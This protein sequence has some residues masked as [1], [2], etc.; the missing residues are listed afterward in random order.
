MGLNNRILQALTIG[1]LSLLISPSV[2]GQFKVRSTTRALL[3]G[4]SEY[5]DPLIPDLKYAHSDAKALAVHLQSPSGGKVKSE[6]IILLTNEEATCGNVHRALNQLLEEAQK[7]DKIYLF[8]SG[9]GDVESIDDQEQGH[10]LLHNTSASVYQLCSVKIEHLQKVITQLSTINQAR[11]ILI[12]DACRSGAL[13]GNAING[14]QA[15]AAAIYQSFNNVVKIMSCQPN[16]FSHEGRQW[17]GGVF[18]HFLIKG[19]TGLADNNGDEVV[20][21]GE[22]G[23]YLEF[24]VSQ[25][26]L[27]H[28]QTPIISGDK[29]SRLS[30]VDVDQM[31]SMAEEGSA[32]TEDRKATNKKSA[33]S[34]LTLKFNRALE[35]KRF[36]ADGSEET[37]AYEIY[38][39]MKSINALRPMMRGLKGDLVS[40]LQDDVQSSIKAYLK[41]DNAEMKERFNRSGAKYVQFPGYMEAAAELLGQEHYLYQQMM[42][43]KYYFEAVNLRLK[44][45]NDRTK[46]TAYYRQAQE[47]IH[48]ALLYEDRAAYIYNELGLISY[49]LRDDD[50]EELYRRAIQL[51]PT[52]AMPYSNLGYFL[53]QKQRFDEAREMS[54]KAIMLHSQM[55][56]PYYNL[57]DIA[58]NAGDLPQAINY[59]KKALEY[60][61]KPNSVNYIGYLHMQNNEIDSAIHYFEMVIDMDSTKAIAYDNLGH[62]YSNQ[63]KTDQAIEYFRQSSALAPEVASYWLNLGYAYQTA[64]KHMEAEECYLKSIELDPKF[65]ASRMNYGILFYIQGKYELAAE[66]FDYISNHINEKNH[67]PYFNS[68]CSYANLGRADKAMEYLNKLQTLGF[69]DTELLSTAPDLI[70]LRERDDFQQLIRKMEGK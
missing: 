1:L 48:E 6:D 55:A 2:L 32:M 30:F 47:M 44:G 23:N 12:S 31:K 69:T 5:H 16:E 15:T 29:K 13:A 50:C 68:A 54:E 18:T 36:I 46:R 38:Q 9:H 3:V 39:D 62:I 65:E 14:A 67:W 34:D 26:V 70:S 49:R 43:K 33:A 63:G 22:V 21:L 8:F 56:Q 7:N 53:V 20:N 10:L 59:S 66:Q 52:W 28:E 40:A 19:L 60:H 35:E 4:I 27:P 57:S 58:Q 61:K 64:E 51:S 42:A 41:T 17:N 45:D 11:V 37:S 24:E 25:A